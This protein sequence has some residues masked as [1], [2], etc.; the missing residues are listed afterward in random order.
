MRIANCAPRDDSSDLMVTDMSLCWHSA[1]C[2]E[3]VFLGAFSLTLFVG[4]V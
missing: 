3:L 1:V 2:K 4:E